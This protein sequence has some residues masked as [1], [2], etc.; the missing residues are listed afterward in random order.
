MG[1]CERDGR[2]MG[3]KCDN[4][5]NAYALDR[6]GKRRVGEYWM[7]SIPDERQVYWCI[8]SGVWM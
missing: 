8:E 6:E 7:V 2:P 3:W 5:A 4:L 1:V